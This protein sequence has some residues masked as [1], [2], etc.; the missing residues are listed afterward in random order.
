MTSP[1]IFHRLQTPPQARN[2]NQYKFLLMLAISIIDF[3]TSKAGSQMCKI[4]LYEKIQA[5]DKT[6]KDYEANEELSRGF[7]IFELTCLRQSTGESRLLV[8]A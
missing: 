8:L 3:Y 2:S 5:F 6:I 1:K 7:F 4:H